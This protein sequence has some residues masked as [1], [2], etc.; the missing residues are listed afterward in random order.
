MRAKNMDGLLTILHDAT[1]RLSNAICFLG[2]VPGDEAKMQQRDL[3]EIRECLD[4]AGR[5]LA[6]GVVDLRELT[7]DEK[8]WALLFQETTEDLEPVSNT[9]PVLDEFSNAPPRSLEQE[10]LFDFTPVDLSEPPD[11][12]DG[13]ELGPPSQEDIPTVPII[14]VI[15]RD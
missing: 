8:A 5:D 6:S 12:L 4:R 15:S 3:T 11:L 7:F 2:N 13:I 10:D 14:P 9:V 1:V